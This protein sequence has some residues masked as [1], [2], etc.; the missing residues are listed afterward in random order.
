MNSMVRRY[1]TV[2]PKQAKDSGMVIEIR[3]NGKTLYMVGEMLFP[4]IRLYIACMLI[5]VSLLVCFTAMAFKAPNGG[6]ETIP[7]IIA[8]ATAWLA[9]IDGK[10]SYRL[11][12]VTNRL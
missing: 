2:K 6:Y 7:M 5:G 11:W 1:N 10:A 12:K 4:A 8:W 3:R 9:Y